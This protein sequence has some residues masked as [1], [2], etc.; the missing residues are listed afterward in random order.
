MCHDGLY[1]FVWNSVPTKSYHIL[2]VMRFLWNCCRVTKVNLELIEL[3]KQNNTKKNR[4]CFVIALC[5][6]IKCYGIV[7]FLDFCIYLS[8]KKV[9]K[10]SKNNGQVKHYNMRGIVIANLS[11]K[12]TH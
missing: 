5:Y 6:S 3:P 7:D 1:T 8:M 4:N 12:I 11:T 2:Q 10:N 9:K